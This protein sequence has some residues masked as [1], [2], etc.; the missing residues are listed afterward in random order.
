MSLDNEFGIYA[1]VNKIMH[2]LVDTD[3][4]QPKYRGNVLYVSEENGDLIIKGEANEPEALGYAVLK[5]YPTL[6]VRIE[7]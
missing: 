3:P 2:E 7:A 5:K 6:K 4:K 1:P